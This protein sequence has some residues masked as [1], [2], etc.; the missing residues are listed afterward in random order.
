MTQIQTGVCQEVRRQLNTQH[1][2]PFLSLLYQARIVVRVTVVVHYLSEMERNTSKWGLLVGVKDVLEMDFQG[3]IHE[4]HMST[5]G[6]ERLLVGVG[7]RILRKH[8]AKAMSTRGMTVPLHLRSLPP[9]QTAMICRAIPTSLMIRVD[10]MKST[11]ILVGPNFPFRS[12]NCMT[13]YTS[14]FA[15]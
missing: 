12:C 14:C 15:C 10:G 11:T 6:F 8:C 9:I 13:S 7:K 2:F 4:Y 5:I 1:S 3:F